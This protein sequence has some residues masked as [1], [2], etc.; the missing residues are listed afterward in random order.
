MQII[1]NLI[2]TRLLLL[3]FLLFLPLSLTHAE[4]VAFPTAPL[5]IQTQQ[6]KID[7][8]VEVATTDAQH[9]HGL[10]FR[11]TLPDRHG[12]IFIFSQLQQPVFWMKNTLIPLDMLFIDD[13]GIITQVFENAP[14]ES[15][16]LIPANKPTR[17]VIELPGGTSAHY[18][19]ASGDKVIYSLFP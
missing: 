12:M 10:M 1:V 13:H 9:E 5:A 11:K 19:I 15:T 18:H 2:H 6:G 4:E 3:L 7:L 16:D 8:T 14:P 17:A